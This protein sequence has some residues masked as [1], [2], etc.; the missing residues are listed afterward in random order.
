MFRS[1]YQSL[2]GQTIIAQADVDFE[3]PKSYIDE[4][5]RALFGEL[6]AME[7]KDFL[8]AVFL[9]YYGDFSHTING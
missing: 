1:M 6:A 3:K 8:V 5:R 9:S 2:T 4:V 7:Q